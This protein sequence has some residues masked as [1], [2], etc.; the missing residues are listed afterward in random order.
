MLA[1]RTG[2][3]G[4]SLALTLVTVIICLSSRAHREEHCRREGDRGLRH[5]VFISNCH[6]HFFD[7][8]STVLRDAATASFGRA[9]VYQRSRARSPASP[10]RS[11]NQPHDPFVPGSAFL[12]RRNTSWPFG[13]FQSIAKSPAKTKAEEYGERAAQCEEVAEKTRVR[14]I[15]RELLSSW[16]E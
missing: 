1:K 11:G 3:E 2:V 15:R 8:S 6:V 5:H 12:I 9:S 16:H 14:D 4:K 7:A 10:R 13:V